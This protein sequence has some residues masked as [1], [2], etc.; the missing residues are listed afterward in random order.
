MGLRNMRG[1]WQY[2][3]RTHG[4]DV[5]VTTALAATERNESKALKL[6]IAHRQAIEEGRWGFRPLVP[7]GFSDIQQDFLAWCK[8]EHAGKPNTWRRIQ[9]SMASCVAFFG[10]QMI[11]MI[12]PGDV[13]DYKV[14]RLTP[15]PDVPAVRDVTAKHDLDNLSVFFRWAVKRDYARLNPCKEVKRPSDS[16]AIRER[17]LTPAEEKLYF[18]NALGNLGKVGRLILLQ[19]MRPEEAMSLPKAAIDL[20]KGTLKVLAGKTPAAKR[21]L[22]LTQEAR[23]I[24][25]AQMHTPGPWVFP[26]PKKPGAHISKL[27]CPHDRV[28]DKLNPCRSCGEPEGKHPTKK[29]STFSSPIRGV[30]FVMYDL[31]HT[32]ATRMVEAGVDLVALKDILGHENIRITMRYVHLSQQRQ[33]DAMVIYDRLNEERRKESIQ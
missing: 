28:L 23:S 16:Q 26:S 24:L 10:R 12:Q 20:E 14:W 9:T 29:C 21:T 4:Q 6:E 7:K 32:F 13:E 18:A 5:C 8:I 1:K 22:K 17:I 31:R 2:R 3:F 19:G 11:S 15:R 30:Y 33:D 25:A 27:N